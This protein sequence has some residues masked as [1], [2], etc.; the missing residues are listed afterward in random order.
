MAD[1]LIE[2]KRYLSHAQELQVAEANKNSRPHTFRDGDKGFISMKNLPPT[3]TNTTENG[4]RKTLQ[5]KYR[6]PFELGRWG[7]ENTFEIEE[8]AAHWK[9]S[10][11]FNV[12]R[13]KVVSN[14]DHTRKAEPLPPLWLETRAG[15]EQA[16]YVE[17]IRSCR[18]NTEKDLRIE[19]ETK[20]TG[21]T[22]PTWELVESFRE[23]AHEVLTEFVSKEIVPAQVVP[24]TKPKTKLK[25]HPKP[26]KAKRAST[27]VRAQSDVKSRRAVGELLGPDGSS[28]TFGVYFVLFLLVVSR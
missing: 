21:H 27:R 5:H 10:P 9:L 11:A 15:N 24:K 3:Y 4:H 14:V 7:A 28:C 2:L 22:G 20:W 26:G 13:L 1:I 23:R 6:G 16:A 19:Y 8:I 25:T 17:E 12:D 18:R